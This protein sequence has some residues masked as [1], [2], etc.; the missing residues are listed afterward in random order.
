[1]NLALRLLSAGL[2][3]TC[4]SIPVHA[5]C[6][7]TIKSSYVGT[8]PT[9]HR[10]YDWAECVGSCGCTIQTHAS[11]SYQY[12]GCPGSGEQACCHIIMEGYT[13]PVT[14]KFVPTGFAKSGDCPNC[15]TTGACLFDGA[16]TLWFDTKISVLCGY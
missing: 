15:A 5:Q 10:E 1:M 7:G 6:S 4:A 8:W 14:G 12:C 13:D 3:L 2:A 11:G 16:E 9:G